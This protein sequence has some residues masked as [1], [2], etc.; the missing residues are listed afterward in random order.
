MDFPP[1]IPADIRFEP[2]GTPVSIAYDDVYFSRENGLSETEHVF[3]QGN[4][5]PERFA[6]A[7]SFTI[8]E[9]GFGT[10]LN[11]LAACRLFD[12]IAPSDARLHCLSIEKHPL[13]KPA[14]I[15]SLSYFP[16]IATYVAILAAL[17]PPAIPGLHRL[18]LSE[19]ISLTLAF[20]DSVDLLPLLNASVDAWFL[21]GFA[22]AKNPGMWE[23]S[24]FS[25]IARLSKPD[26]TA[27]TFTVAGAV[28]RGLQ[29]AGF[30]IEKREGFGRKR[31]MLV[32]EKAA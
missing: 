29:E 16:E 20:G 3:L 2:N 26:A 18:Q 8:A 24:A 17:Y 15:Q 5:L 4:R 14:L 23:Q 25:H 10:G 31:E 13:P 28:Q 6:R 27:A 9:M 7:T 22:P 19:R 30:R 32:A 12:E 11:I 1:I 21:D